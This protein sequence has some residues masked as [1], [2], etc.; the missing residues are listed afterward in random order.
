MGKK[1]RSEGPGTF[2]WWSCFAS[3]P[4]YFFNVRHERL[5]LDNEGEEL[6]DK[7]AAWREATQIIGKLM[8]EIDGSLRPGRDLRLEVTDEFKN[9]LYVIRVVAERSA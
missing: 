3:M 4:K 1:C 5:S 9:P 2:Y 6:S 7:H 8:Q